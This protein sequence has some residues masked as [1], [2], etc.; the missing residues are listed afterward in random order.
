MRFVASKSLIRFF[1]VRGAVCVVMASFLALCATGIAGG[2]KPRQE[3][4]ET[5]G[6][7]PGLAPALKAGRS[8]NVRVA[9]MLRDN[10]LL[11]MT[12]RRPAE[13]TGRLPGATA[14]KR[15][16]LR[17]PNRV[18]VREA[19][20]A[21]SM[22]D[23]R[24]NVLSDIRR[25]ARSGTAQSVRVGEWIVQNGGRVVDAQPL[26]NS[27]TA[28]VPRSQLARLAR[29]RGVAAVL[30]AGPPPHWLNDLLEGSQTWHDNGFTGGGTSADGNGGPD[31]NAFDQG[32]RTTH[33]AFRTRMPGDCSTC[34]ASGPT[35]VVSPER[36]TDFSGSEHGNQVAATVADT[37]LRSYATGGAPFPT[38]WQ[39]NKGM[40]FD[41]DKL[42]DPWA[43][44]NPPR[45][46]IGIT[47]DGEP[48]VSDLPEVLNYSAGVIA[49]TTDFDPYWRSVDTEVDQLA[50]TQTISAGNCGIVSSYSG[51]GDGPHR[52]EIPGTNFNVITVGG[53]QT[54][55]PSVGWNN[56]VN[57]TVWSNSSP[58]PT[59]GG[60]K[61]PDLLAT[62]FGAVSCPNDQDDTTT[63]NCGSGTSYAA[64]QVAAGAILL[65][66]V[67]VYAP[68]AQKAILINS[69]TPIQGQTYWM[70]RSGWGAL[71]LDTA[72]T[73][74]ANYAN[75]S[76]TAAGANS[77]RFYRLTGVAAGDRT[78]L[79][80]NR[81]TVGAITSPA[82][83]YTT[84]TNLDLFQFAAADACS[85]S[86]TPTATGGVDANDTVDTDQTVTADNPMP[87]NGTDGGDNV[88]QLR[89]T[90]T[91]TQ[92]VKVK[93]MSTIDGATSEPFSIASARPVEALS[94][95]IPSV[96]LVPSASVAGPGQTVT[97]TATVTNPSDD[98]ALSGGAITLALPAGASL[99]T[100]SLSQSLGTIA[101]SGT[102]AVSWQVSGAVDGAEL[103]TATVSGTAFAEA[104]EGSGQAT[105]TVDATAPVV[106]VD[107]PGEWS[108]SNAPTFS[109]NA[110]DASSSVANYD[111]EIS[112]NGGVFAPLL[113]ASPATSTSVSGGEGE[114][115]RIRV[116]ARDTFGNHSGWSEATTTI[117]A[118]PPAIAFGAAS[119]GGRST[120]T[121]P[122]SVTNVGSQ[123][124]AKYSFKSGPAT[125]VPLNASTVSFTNFTTA[126]QTATLRVT[127][128]DALG[129][130]VTETRAYT[131]PSRYLSPALTVSRVKAAGSAIVVAGR[132]A[133]TYAGRVTVTI[134]RKGKSGTRRV[135]KRVRV[136]RGKFSAKIKVRSGRYNVRVVA[137]AYGEYVAAAAEK[138]LRVR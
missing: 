61:K 67:G 75:G 74:R 109:W 43:A 16:A 23:A 19:Q 44:V 136:K 31:F 62:T 116:R 25:A 10:G 29:L 60:R 137:P 45:W 77:A 124:A 38:T 71:N 115:L 98:L 117:D 104:F 49:D 84:L 12:Q 80:W 86:C 128:T 57:W 88:E 134:K 34:V 83:A 48:G 108:A 56:P 126:T 4:A 97:V 79:V 5:A 63:E 11:T 122:V 129:R 99:V 20:I 113:A 73:Q 30:P 91:G 102:A 103:F 66:S 28:V 114:Q 119:F 82:L 8:A 125:D 6:I 105:Y 40:A 58:G 35:R 24:N 95:P 27:I 36:R 54:T 69:A 65:A 93:A 59:W 118:V 89:S 14:A 111:A 101:A 131:V 15:A 32:V 133:K 46:S 53:F 50:I 47:Y 39:P 106:Q 112:R 110:S 55:F 13:L 81:R 121:V 130:A 100:G 2:S 85:P 51:C 21:A 33:D 26:P 64:P 87:G 9:V 42:Y 132:T 7:S 18:T 1:G 92:I 17:S 76:V 90:G 41:L 127:A 52:V 72:F 70:P 3:R 68:T 22:D 107:N 94:T 120:I 135:V 123:V 96:A 78:T 138:R 37:D